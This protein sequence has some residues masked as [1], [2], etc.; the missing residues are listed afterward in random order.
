MPMALR[1]STLET[2]HPGP[3][4]NDRLHALRT[5]PNDTVK[6][7]KTELMLETQPTE[8]KICNQFDYLFKKEK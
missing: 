4:L 7:L 2:L 6:A 8:I 3:R 1:F 5:D